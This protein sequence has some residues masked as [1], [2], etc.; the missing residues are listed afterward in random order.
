[1][2]VG[3]RITWNEFF[4][5]FCD[6]HIPKSV[7][8]LKRDE[9]CKL[10]QGNKSVQEY[11]NAFNYL[12]QYASH[13]VDDDEKKQDCYMEGLSLKLKAQ[14]SNIG[15][16]DFNDLV[17]KSIKAEYNLNALEVDNRKRVA[18]SSMGGSSSSQRPRTGPSPPPRILG[19]GAPQPMWMARH[20]PAL[21]GQPPRPSGQPGGGGGSSSSSKGSC[22]NCG[23]HGHVPKPPMPPPPNFQKVK[24]AQPPKR[25]KLNHITAEEANDDELVLVGM[26][27]L[28]SI[29]TR[30]LFDSGSSHSFMSRK[31]AFEHH[32]PFRKV[33]IPF[34][35]DAP[36]ATLV[37]HEV[38]NLAELDVVGL[39]FIVNF[40]VI[41]L[42]DFD[43][44]IS[45][46]WMTKHDGVI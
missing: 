8:K 11:T 32:F 19:F 10:K 33:P 37:T 22:Y 30:T 25:G 1:V 14:H 42:E 43:I 45:M 23:G 2:P 15:F 24:N 35:I 5:A 9:F 3:H 40:V 41:D 29:N 28:N 12:S 17:S 16:K 27:S 21:Q 18:P 26:V 46:N 39:T 34:H 38:V 20:P 13:D 4:K 31:F 6:H 7:L 36:G 44:I